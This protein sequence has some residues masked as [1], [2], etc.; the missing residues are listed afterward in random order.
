M[1]EE[2]ELS[3]A[4]DVGTRVPAQ[5]RQALVLGA[6]GALGAACAE[7]LVR[8]GAVVHRSS[9]RGGEGL[10]AVDGSCP[11]GLD[12]LDGLPPLDAVV[13]AQGANRNDEVTGFDVEAFREVMEANVTFVLATLHRLHD[14]GRLRAPARLVVLSSIWERAARPG[15][16]SYT[17]SKAAVGGLV[18]AVATDLAPEGHLVNAVLPS[19][20][21]TPMTRAVLSSEQI[22]TTEAATG[23]NRLIEPRD[24]A[25]ATA[26]LCSPA[27]RSITGQSITV[28]L[29]LC[30]V[31]HL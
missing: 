10:I 5:S 16:L 3:A 30:H 14:S 21:D 13:W 6:N 15:K 17:V 12:E 27:N 29:G 8:E 9:R 4:A 28:D 23:F 25:E 22:A 19:V 26:W 20:T 11:G 2:T 31:R 24:V 1:P 7:A 18:R